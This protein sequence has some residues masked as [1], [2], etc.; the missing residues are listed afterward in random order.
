MHDASVYLGR[1]PRLGPL[2]LLSSGKV[3]DQYVLDDQHVVFVTSDRVSAFDVVM[4]EGI[5]HKGRVLTSIAAWWF[6]H[7]RDV[8]ENHLVST[9][10]DDLPKLDARAKD[11]L[12]GRVMIVRRAV[13]TSVE[14]VV[15]GYLAGSGWKEY[16]RSGRLWDQAV[17]AGL[18]ESAALPRPLLTPT[19]K[20]QHHDLPLSLEQ[21]RERVGAEVFERAQ[22]AA[23]ELFRRGG[24]LLESRG[25]LLAD[26]KFE[27]GLC[28]GALLLIDE[29]LTPDSSRFWPSDGYR[30]GRTQPSF[31]KQ[32]L[33]N[34]LE[35]SG[36][37]KEPPPPTLSPAIIAEVGAR[38]LEICERITGTRPD[39]PAAASAR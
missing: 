35:Q 11:K 36:W 34:W 19:T 4:N 2:Q 23:L 3:R 24:E 16:Q 32:V 18:Q 6:E 8:I 13:P 30:P 20:E 10:V 25:I 15:R 7:T 22:T 37:N 1:E 31:D 27:F 28:N 21:T 17:P 39:M 12:R 26:T 14:W 29:A 9:S 5:P 33:R 38:Y